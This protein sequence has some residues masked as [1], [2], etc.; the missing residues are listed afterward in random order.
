MFP[1]FRFLCQMLCV[2]V[3]LWMVAVIERKMNSPPETFIKIHLAR[4]KIFLII[5]RIQGPTIA[6]Q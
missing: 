5:T 1:Y 3:L 2:T 6:H 4:N